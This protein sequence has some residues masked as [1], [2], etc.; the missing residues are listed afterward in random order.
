LWQEHLAAGEMGGATAR[1]VAMSSA[2][3]TTLSFRDPQRRP[4][5]MSEAGAPQIGPHIQAVRKG[6]QLTLDDLAKSSGVSRSMLSQIERGQANPSLATVWA[7]CNAL[8]IDISELIVGQVSERRPHIEVASASFTPEIKTEDGSCTLRILSPANHAEEYEWY[9]L[10]FQPGGALDS[11]PHAKGTRE[12]LTVLEGA[13]QVRVGTEEVD[14]PT[15]ATARYP[16]DVAHTI[17][18]VGTG[19]TRALLVMTD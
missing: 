5:S 18:A 2:C 4:A 10:I 15:G 19:V 14:V 6:R 12:H 1:I 17:T 8:K 16:A 7:L 11:Q 13:A 3:A 9:E